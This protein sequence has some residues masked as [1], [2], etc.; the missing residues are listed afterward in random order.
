MTI[1]YLINNIMKRIL[2]LLALIPLFASCDI[3]GMID[4]MTRLSPTIK[5]YSYSSDGQISLGNE[6]ANK[7]FTAFIV[8]KSKWVG[9]KGDKVD[10]QAQVMG[11]KWGGDPDKLEI[12]Y[13]NLVT[14]QETTRDMSKSFWE[15]VMKD[16][17]S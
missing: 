16:I 13:I 15:N 5:G 9:K 2:I 3:N 12:Y 6:D 14:V 10:C 17:M 8:A 4:D 1:N 11:D 7:A